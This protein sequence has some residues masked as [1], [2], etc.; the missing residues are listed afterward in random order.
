MHY[1]MPDAS[2]HTVYRELAYEN[3]LYDTER[4]FKKIIKAE[5]GSVLRLRQKYDQEWESNLIAEQALSDQFYNGNP[6][7]HT[8]SA[9][10]LLYTLEGNKGV[11]APRQ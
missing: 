6:P 10:D 2:V 3:H 1:C 8:K 11:R 7:V 9:W 4:K 5:M